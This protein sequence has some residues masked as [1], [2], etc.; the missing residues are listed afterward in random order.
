MFALISWR[1]NRYLIFFY[2]FDM[3]TI[4]LPYHNQQILVGNKERF[5]C[6]VP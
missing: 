3:S 4:N 6:F 1:E 2:L 5:F